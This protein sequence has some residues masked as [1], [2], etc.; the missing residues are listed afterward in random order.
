MKNVTGEKNLRSVE[1][2]QILSKSI[3]MFFLLASASQLLAHGKYSK[4]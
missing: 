1:L 3:F 2:V 4:I